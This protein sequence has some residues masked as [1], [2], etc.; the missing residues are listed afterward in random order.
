MRDVKELSKIWLPWSRIASN[1][2]VLPRKTKHL[3]ERTIPMSLEDL[4]MLT[5]ALAVVV[6]SEKL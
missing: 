5:G 2:N 3:I 1:Q 4:S 6:R